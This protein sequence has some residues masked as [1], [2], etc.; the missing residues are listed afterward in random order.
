MW[1]NCGGPGCSAVGLTVGGA[2]GRT[3]V[4]VST[5][6]RFG[7]G[8]LLVGVLLLEEP[9][10]GSRGAVIVFLGVLL[11]VEVVLL[12]VEVVLLVVEVVLLV[13]EAVLL[14]LGAVLLVLDVLEVL[15]LGARGELLVV[16]SLANSLR[17]RTQSIF[18]ILSFTPAPFLF[19]M[20]ALMMGIIRLIAWGKVSSELSLRRFLQVF[21]AGLGAS[22]FLLSMSNQFAL[23]FSAILAAIGCS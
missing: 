9:A 21:G 11:V 16:F 8:A 10:W 2:V 19:C 14:V 4:M 18:C 7:R 12:V 22:S 3:T 20:R 17:R 6:A 5:T 1:L 23:Q 13:L 15:V